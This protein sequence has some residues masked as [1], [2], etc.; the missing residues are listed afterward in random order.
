MDFTYGNKSCTWRHTKHNYRNY[1][2]RK[3]V[4]AI[5]S[6]ELFAPPDVTSCSHLGW[7]HI[8]SAILDDIRSAI[9]ECHRIQLAMLDDIIARHFSRECGHLLFKKNRAQLFSRPCFVRVRNA[10]LDLSLLFSDSIIIFAPIVLK[11]PVVLP[12]FP[13]RCLLITSSMTPRASSSA[14]LTREVGGGGLPKTCLGLFWRFVFYCFKDSFYSL[15]RLSVKLTDPISENPAICLFTFTRWVIRY[16][17]K[18]NMTQGKCFVS[19]I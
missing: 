5:I 6:R 9:L 4:G 14:P 15:G 2:S 1:S 11:T 16:V 3:L 8:L 12:W 17:F 19:K 10:L 7:H 13:P 18:H